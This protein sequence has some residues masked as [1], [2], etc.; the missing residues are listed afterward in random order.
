MISCGISE[1]G[2]TS[3]NPQ[4]MKGKTTFFLVEDHLPVEVEHGTSTF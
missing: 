2:E 1:I 3:N 4:R